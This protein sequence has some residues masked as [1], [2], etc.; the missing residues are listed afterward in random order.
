[1]INDRIIEQ[2]SHNDQKKEEERKAIK[3]I[4]KVNFLIGA[5]SELFGEQRKPFQGKEVEEWLMGSGDTVTKDDT[6][7][8]AELSAQHSSITGMV[9]CMN[10]YH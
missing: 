8:E 9:S 1:M 6:G 7:A 2:M 3:S 4:A 10:D 5:P